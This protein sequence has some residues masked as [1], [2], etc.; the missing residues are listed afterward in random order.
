MV[1]RRRQGWGQ[2][3]FDTQGPDS[4]HIRIIP[5]HCHHSE[6]KSS[7]AWAWMQRNGCWRWQPHFVYYLTNVPTAVPKQ[8]TTKVAGPQKP[9]KQQQVPRSL[10]RLGQHSKMSHK[11]CSKWWLLSKWSHHNISSDCIPHRSRT[12][13]QH[14]G[15][16]TSAYCLP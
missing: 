11:S 4:E 16:P 6:T 14:K 1:Q 9:S 13:R 5:K 8:L 2:N 15:F 7:K 3:S 12:Q 10:P